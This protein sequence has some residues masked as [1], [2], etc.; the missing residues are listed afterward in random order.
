M[1]GL[2][3][4]EYSAGGERRG[5]NRRL[6]F[7]NIRL[8]ARQNPCIIFGG[9]DDEHKCSEIR[10]SEFFKNGEKVS[11]LSENQLKIEDFCEDI[12]FES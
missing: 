1:P 6:F 5:K 7:K 11:E 4:P 8:Y 9:Y 12:V 2:Y 10:I 3:H